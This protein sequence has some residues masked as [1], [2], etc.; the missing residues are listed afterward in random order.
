MMKSKAGVPIPQVLSL[1]RVGSVS[2]WKTL[3]GGPLQCCDRHLLPPLTHRC[4]SSPSLIHHPLLCH[5]W[6]VF[7][8]SIC[9]LDG[10]LLFKDK[11]TGKNYET[12]KHFCLQFFI[13]QM[14]TP[15]SNLVKFHTSV[16]T[17]ALQSGNSIPRN[18]LMRKFLH[19][20]RRCLYEQAYSLQCNL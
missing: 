8:M 9:A 13:R 6:L 15:G 1:L 2:P 16:H 19:V 12:I 3:S 5:F 18:L 4:D 17:Y 11:H 20:C 10:D 14:I 7:Y